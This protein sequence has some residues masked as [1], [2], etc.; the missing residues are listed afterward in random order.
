MDGVRMIYWLTDN[1]NQ[2]LRRLL[3]SAN[4]DGS[5][6]SWAELFSEALRAQGV[7]GSSVVQIKTTHLNA[8]TWGPLPQQQ[9][10]APGV[11]LVRNWTF[12]GS[13]SVVGVCDLFPY[14]MDPPTQPLEVS[15][16]QRVPAQGN[17]NSPDGFFNHFIVRLYSSY[18]DPS[19]GSGP[20]S[21]LEA[22][23]NGAF[24]GFAVGCTSDPFVT[25]KPNTVG[26]LEIQAVP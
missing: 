3:N 26:T 11:L 21:S 6:K 5:C 10:G 15:P 12:V 22:E 16:A 19:Y 13:G 4:G 18:Y 17:H 25:A 14:L 7:S 1:P 9:Q 2:E 8:S 20:W 24:A 23:E